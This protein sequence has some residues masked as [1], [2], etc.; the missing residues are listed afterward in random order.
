MTYLYVLGCLLF[1]ALL[2][3]FIGFSVN[4]FFYPQNGTINGTS[5][6]DTFLYNIE[7]APASAND[8]QMQSTV[9]VM[10]IG[11]DQTYIHCNRYIKK[12]AMLNKKLRLLK[13]VTSILIVFFS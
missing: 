4:A 2:N 1:T 10:K 7:V 8:S 6:M 9:N 3:P 12:Y 13:H 5:K 11:P